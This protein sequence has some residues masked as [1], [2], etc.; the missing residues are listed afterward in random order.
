TPHIWPGYDTQTIESVPRWTRELQEVFDHAE[1]P[2]KVLPGG[3]MNLH[4]AVTATPAD[5]IVTMALGK[6][7]MLVDMWS[8]VLPPW[9]EPAVRWLQEMGLTV[10]LAHPERMRAVQDEPSVADRFAEMGI[11]LQG[12]LQ[13]FSDR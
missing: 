12:N 13:C 2:L 5:Q 8:E 7:Y 6:K 3:E 4:P 11:L 9:F 1:V 10:I